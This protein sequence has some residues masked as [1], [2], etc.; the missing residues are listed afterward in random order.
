VLNRQPGPLR[1]RHPGHRRLPQAALAGTAG[2]AAVN[3]A[4]EAAVPPLATEL[5][6]RRVNAVSP[7]VVETDWWQ[8]MP[9]DQ[10]T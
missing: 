7:D 5:A 1:V 2:L 9:A 8:S 3:G 6:P 10:R 4:L